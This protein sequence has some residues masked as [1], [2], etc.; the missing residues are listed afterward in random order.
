[1]RWP[2]TSPTTSATAIPDACPNDGPRALGD[3]LAA[4]PAALED[5]TRQDPAIKRLGFIGRRRE[6]NRAVHANLL[7]S[8]V[9]LAWSTLKYF[10]PG[11]HPDEVRSTAQAVA[12]LASSPAARQ[13][14]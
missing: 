12:Y 8:M 4:V 10:R 2:T 6:Y 3:D 14:G 13:A 9:G 1:M 7:P 11:F 5:I